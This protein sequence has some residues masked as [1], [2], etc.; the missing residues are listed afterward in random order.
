MMDT[1][2][3]DGWRRVIDFSGDSVNNYYAP[4]ISDAR[5]RVLAAGVTINGL[6]ILRPGD[7]G[8]AM[9]GL[10]QRFEEQIIGGRGAFVVTADTR[11]S[12]A[13]AVRRKLILEISG[14]MPGRQVANR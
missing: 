14:T 10:E 6:P 4:P 1:N 9:G 11:E 12:F 5:A 3:H 8:R 13:E 7:P 2:D